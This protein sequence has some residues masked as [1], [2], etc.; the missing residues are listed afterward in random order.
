MKTWESVMVVDFGMS[1]VRA[2]LID[3]YNGSILKQASSNHTWRHLGGG[4]IE[5][6]PEEIWHSSQRV[7]S[8]LLKGLDAKISLLGCSFSF[9][10]AI[11][12]EAATQCHPE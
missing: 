5:I 4:R 12:N 11:G 1:K 10:R 7:V 8:E 3:L 6:D 2:L 9:C